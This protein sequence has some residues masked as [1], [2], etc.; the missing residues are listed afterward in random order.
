MNRLSR[1]IPALLSCLLLLGTVLCGC[2]DP[3][4]TPA[5]PSD[6]QA[7]TGT[8]ADFTPAAVSDYAA[9]ARAT[10]AQ[11]GVTP[12]SA[13]TYELNGSNATLTGYTGSA[14]VVVVPETLEGHTVTAVASD[15]FANTTV[16]ALSIPDTV[17]TLGKGILTGCTTLEYLELPMIGRTRTDAETA[18]LGYL[19][20]ASAKEDNALRV[21][22]SLTAVLLTDGTDLPAYAFF[23]CND[24]DGV[25]L[26][27]GMR[28]IGRYAFYGCD[29]LRQADLP[30]SLET[31]EEG[32]FRDCSALQRLELPAGVRSIGRSALDGCLSLQTLSLPFAGGSADENGY[33]G[34]LFG[35]STYQHNASMVPASLKELTL[36]AAVALPDFALYGCEDLLTVHLPDT[37]TSIGARAL[38]G[39]TLLQTLTLPD[40]VTSVG[41]CAFSGCLSL[42]EVAFGTGL[43]ALGEQAFFHCVSL[44]ELVLPDGLATIPASA[45][46]GCKALEA[47]TLPA[48][49]KT[50]EADAFRGC[51][52]F[53]ISGS[54]SGVSVAEGNDALIE[55]AT[56]NA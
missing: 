7:E 41:A 48:S 52:A 49:L 29:S 28:S 20:G 56:P 40:P 14:R 8:V 23:D 42:R 24:L 1:R 17:R 25:S 33:L 35:A 12:A 2:K 18:Y 47:V 21:P 27:D 15:A 6:L 31:V 16:T 54:L 39:C 30:T 50:I 22:S 3:D 44:K 55:K 38:S 32:A 37:L 4:P 53:R 46:A 43:T 11:A 51:E 36:T 9:A 10:F 5:D 19:F 13:F 26:P 34:Y 45:F